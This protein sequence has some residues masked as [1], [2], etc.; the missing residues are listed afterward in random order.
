MTKESKVNPQEEAKSFDEVFNDNA[1]NSN[2]LELETKTESQEPQKKEEVP[3]DNEESQKPQSKEELPDKGDDNQESIDEPPSSKKEE[4]SW[5]KT[6]VI[7]ERRKRQDLEKKF[8]E[9]DR[10]FVELQAQKV[11][12]EKAKRPDPIEDPEGA[13]NFDKQESK[14]GLWEMKVSL[15]QDF[16]RD[17]HK[18]YDEME[19]KFQEL[20]VNNVYLSQQLRLSANP[21]RFAYQTAKAHVESQNFKDP[22]YVKN[23][24]EEMKREV[25]AELAGNQKTNSG[26]KSDVKLPTNLTNMTSVASNLTPKEDYKGDLAEV[27]GEES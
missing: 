17:K 16:M 26:D 27:F 25:L 5:T 6:A 22:S 3:K 1:D 11:Q 19:K 2:E 12:K 10:R 18:D 4:E 9:L 21:A 20:V 14:Q 23:L 15:S 13:A 24:K 8:A 7:D